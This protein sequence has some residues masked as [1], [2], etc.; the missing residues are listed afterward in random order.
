MEFK[1]NQAIYLQIADHFLEN[2]LQ[3]KWGKGDKI[4]SIRD[5]AI[6]FEVNPNTTMR[7]FNYLQEKEIIFNKRGMGYYVAEDGYEKTLQLKKEK[8]IAEEIPAFFKTMGLL[9]IS[10]EDL[11][12][13][14]HP[15]S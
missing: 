3:K 2:I 11:Q 6:A 15:S 8:F 1:N 12:T 13:Y 14:V 7:T 10:F 4:P 9:G 5:L